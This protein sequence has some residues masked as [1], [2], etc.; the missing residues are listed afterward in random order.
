MIHAYLFILNV[1]EGNGGHGPNFQRIMININKAVGTNITV[2]ETGISNKQNSGNLRKSNNLCFRFTIPSTT[3][4]IFTKLIFGAAMA[5][6][7]IE[8]H[9]SDTFVGQRIGHQVQ[10]INGG[11]NITNNVAVIFLKFLN[12]IRYRRNERAKRALLQAL[13]PITAAKLI[14]RAGEWSKK[15]HHPQL[16]Q[17]RRRLC[18]N[19]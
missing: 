7:S 8:A 13:L 16:Q 14:I 6:V 3:K 17:K 2:S 10:T 5:F 1:R 4:L 15:L 9:F 12:P 11:S 18:K 19:P